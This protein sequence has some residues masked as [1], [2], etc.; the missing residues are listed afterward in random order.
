MGHFCFGGVMLLYC[1]D[2]VVGIVDGDVLLFIVVT[3]IVELMLL[4]IM[5]FVSKK[6]VCVD[7]I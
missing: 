4:L 2:N 1:F 5:C 7:V 3:L 6:T